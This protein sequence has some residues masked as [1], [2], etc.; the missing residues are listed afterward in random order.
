MLSRMALRTLFLDFNSYFASVEQQAR[1]ELRGRPVVVAPVEAETT[2]CIAVSREAKLQGVRR[3]M[4]VLE[5]RRACPKVEVVL[6]RPPLYVDYHHRLVTAVD[7]CAP[8]EEVH[9]IDEMACALPARVRTR[10]QAVELAQ[11]VKCSIAQRVG[12]FLRCSIGIAPNAF[13]AKAACEMEKPDGLVVLEDADLPAALYK[14]EPGDFSG[15][16]RRVEARLRR[17][18]ISTVEQLVTAPRPLLRKIWGSVEGERIHDLLHGGEAKRLPTKR[19]LISHAHVLAPDQRNEEIAFAVLNRLLQKAAM[20]LRRVRHLARGLSLFVEYPHAGDCSAELVFRE[21][22]DTLELSSALRRLWEQRPRRGR[23]PMMVG[24]S[25][26]D[27]IAE[28]ALTPS[29]FP[30]ETHERR[31]RLDA[32]MDALNA[33]LGKNTVYFATAHAARDSAPMRIAFNYIPDADE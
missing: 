32:A 19:S 22:Q 11:S 21:T 27:L 5:A 1:P 18:G 25:L 14:L 10:E 3:G 20:R 23:S 29:L 28:E 7:A 12:E 26:F 4:R 8:V 2:C 31:A 15:I 30:D 24:V 9:S 6:A 17:A 33:R 13:L 16:G